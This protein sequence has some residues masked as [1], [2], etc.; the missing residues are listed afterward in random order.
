METVGVGLGDRMRSGISLIHAAALAAILLVGCERSAPN[1]AVEERKPQQAGKPVNPYEVAGHITAARVSAVLGDAETAE[2]HV[3]AIATG[4]T[5]S[6]RMPD[7]YRRIDRESARTAVRPIPGVRSSVWLDR[8]NFIVM[9]DGQRH[10]S[11]AMI[12]EVCLALE[13]LGDSLAVVV[14]VQDVTATTPDGAT[15]LSR[16]CQLPEGQR[17]FM[18]KKRQ[19]DVVSRELQDAFN[20]QQRQ[21]WASAASSEA[22]A[23]RALRSW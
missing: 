4:I 11:M 5:R 14:N 6:A 23:H 2:E 9:V 21:D 3:K 16:N 18:Q 7:A 20:K 1:A 10:R 12:D 8:E 19:V 22:A 17:A 15:T 13:P